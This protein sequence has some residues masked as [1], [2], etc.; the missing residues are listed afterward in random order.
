MKLFAIDPGP[1]YSA[2]VLFDGNRV[3]DKMK[4][5]NEEM[6]LLLTMHAVNGHNLAIE[7]IASYGRPVGE[8]VFETCVWIGR[9]TQQAGLNGRPLHRLFRTDVKKHLCHQSTKIS[10]AVIRQ[11]LIDIFGP[12]QKVACGTKKNPGP[13]YGVTKDIWAALAV[14]VTWWEQNV[15]TVMK[16]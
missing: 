12:G 7:M 2:A 10:D 6:L 3:L 4:I 5:P 11:R 14:A 16:G 9:F 13:L 15:G 1:V 8:E